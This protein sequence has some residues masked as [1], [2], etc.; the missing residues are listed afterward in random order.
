VVNDFTGLSAADQERELSR[1]EERLIRKVFPLGEWPFF[2]LQVSNLHSLKARIHLCVDM[3]IADGASI[4]LLAQEL[5]T[6][7]ANPNVPLRAPR[8]SFQDYSL[9]LQEFRRSAEGRKCA[10]YW[11]QKFSTIPGGPV[12]PLQENETK[13]EGTYRLSASLDGWNKLRTKA[14]QLKVQ[15][16]IILLTA[17]AEVLWSRSTRRPFSLA[18][19]CWQRPL[20]HTELPQVVGDFTA[21]AW[22]VVE[23]MSGT[24]S[25][26]VLRT[27]QAVQSDLKHSQVSGLSA[28][29]KQA[30]KRR[31]DEDF[32]F[33]IVFTDLSPQPPL[34]LPPGISFVRSL[35]WTTHVQ[36]D[37]MSLELGDAL[38]LYWDVGRGVFPPGLVEGMF[39][40]YAR[41]LTD[42][43]E[44]ETS[45]N[46]I[47]FTHLARASVLPSVLRGEIAPK[48]I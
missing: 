48:V 35:S 27:H 42:L 25:D 17:F 5:F 36:I 38:G 15:P 30:A 3:L 40:D 41:I 7:Y 21:M 1:I 46:T 16:A 2:E 8:I 23:D 32:R 22:L 29:R 18:V 39:S 4:D 43:A 14:E 20:L 13:I 9:Y 31:H 28:L 12:L 34:D 33:P 11:A 26:R 10:D 47:N 24:F 37:N 44:N 45:W 6:A 19:P